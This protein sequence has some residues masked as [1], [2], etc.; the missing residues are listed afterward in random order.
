MK[1]IKTKE[2]LEQN[3]RETNK[4]ID[5]SISKVAHKH[6]AAIKEWETENPGYENSNN[7]QNTSR[8]AYNF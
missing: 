1:T 3:K 6:L 2:T 4:K 7:G 5:I 8:W